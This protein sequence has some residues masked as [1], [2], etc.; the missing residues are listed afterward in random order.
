V[1][2]VRPRDCPHSQASAAHE[3]GRWDGCGVV[4]G[5]D[6]PSVSDGAG[7]MDV[8]GITPEVFGAEMFGDTGTPG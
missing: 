8:P 5:V 7:G 1:P 6:V 2:S 4:D 3:L